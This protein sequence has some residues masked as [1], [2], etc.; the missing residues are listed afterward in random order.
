MKIFQ[1]SLVAVAVLFGLLTIFAGT[2][3]LLGSNPG[4]LVF[5]PLLIYN[6]A[7]GVVYVAAGI[8]AWR[9]IRQGM[10]VAAAISVLNLIVLTTIFFLYTEGNAIAVDSLRAMSLR[11]AV[12]LALFAGFWWLCRS[13]KFDSI[14]P[15]T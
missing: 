10:Y 1:N 9:N 5:R 8:I 3:V 7:M 2:R 11:T 4:Y 15:D 13:N 6:A 12:W 14:K